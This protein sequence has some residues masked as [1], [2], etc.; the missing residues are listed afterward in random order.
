MLVKLINGALLVNINFE[1]SDSE[2]DDN[3]CLCF[4]EPCLEEEK[5]FRA[6]QTNIFLTPKEAR[7][8]AQALINAANHSDLAST[9]SI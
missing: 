5:V 7:N 2:Y 6:E 9:D 4:E 1:T 3:I 8:L